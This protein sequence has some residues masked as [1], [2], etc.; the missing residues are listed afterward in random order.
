MASWCIAHVFE[1]AGILILRDIRYILDIR[2]YHD[3]RD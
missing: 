3:Y 1:G 2:D